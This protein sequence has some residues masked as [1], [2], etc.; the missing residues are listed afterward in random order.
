MKP[1]DRELADAIFDDD[2]ED[3]DPA[4]KELNKQMEFALSLYN[5]FEDVITDRMGSKRPMF[6][7][8]PANFSYT[9]N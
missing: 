4:T 9:V 5:L 2:E 3:N 8:P 6:I 7:A 1:S